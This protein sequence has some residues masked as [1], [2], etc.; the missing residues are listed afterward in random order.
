MGQGWRLPGGTPSARRAPNARR[1]EL[2]PLI[3]W[4]G[5]LTGRHVHDAS[6]ARAPSRATAL[7]RTACNLAPSRCHHDRPAASSRAIDPTTPAARRCVRRSLA[8]LSR[9]LINAEERLPGTWT[10]PSAL[11]S[12]DMTERNAGM[13]LPVTRVPH[14]RITGRATSRIRAWMSRRPARLPRVS[15][16]AREEAWCSWSGGRQIGSRSEAAAGTC[17]VLRPRAGP[18]GRLVPQGR[19]TTLRRRWPPRG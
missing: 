5:W 8:E 13:L 17:Q 9:P 19:T 15:I 14:R 4:V 3:G 12:T 18:T 6:Q 7:R 11:N 1:A 16:D 2:D 10:S